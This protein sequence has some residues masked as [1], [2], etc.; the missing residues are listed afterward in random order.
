MWTVDLVRS[1][2][3]SLMVL[4]WSYVGIR[5][6]VSHVIINVVFAVAAAQKT[7]ELDLGKLGEFL[8]KKLLPYCTVYLIIKVFGQDAGL[9]YLSAPILVIIELT[10]AGN[11]A[12]NLRALGLP[13]PKLITALIKV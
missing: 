8:F 9:D 10:L 13:L 4:A 5:V 7:G 11:L 12:D 2:L 1:F 3:Q 6:I